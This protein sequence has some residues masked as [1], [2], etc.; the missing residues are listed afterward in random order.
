MAAVKV[1]QH[2]FRALI[3]LDPA[4][5][6]HGVQ[7]QLGRR[8]TCCLVRTC[9]STY[10][11]AVISPDEELAP[12]AV[13][14][15]VVRI[16]LAVGEAG[17]FFAP[18]QRF[19]VWADALAGHAVH[20]DCL[21]AHGII[22]CSLSFPPRAFDGRADREA[23]GPAGLARLHCAYRPRKIMAIAWRDE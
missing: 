20:A 23:A 10:F 19:T 9:Y 3:T 5:G 8:H 12:R 18:G 13:I 14:P 21:I 6:E 7:G 4:A 16:A 2:R 1:M 15:A 11:P 17:A 22:A